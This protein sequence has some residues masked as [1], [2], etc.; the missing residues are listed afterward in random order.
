MTGDKTTFSKDLLRYLEL[1]R[2][3]T[4]L[5]LAL[6]FG[7]EDKADIEFLKGKVDVAVVGSQVI[8]MIDERGVGAVDGFI[9]K[10]I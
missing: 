10:L 9:R 3:A 6:G 8:R 7:V 1:C 2:T 5:P 4:Q